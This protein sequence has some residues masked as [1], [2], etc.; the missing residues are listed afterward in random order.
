MKITLITSG[1]RGDVEPYV[2]LAEGLKDSGHMVTIA[3]E[4]RFESFVLGR[5]LKFFC[6]P[7]DTH[8]AINSPEGQAAL[9]KKDNTASFLNH[10]TN[11]SAA[12][13]TETIS[14]CLAAC[15]DA[16]H[17]ICT[18]FSLH[19]AY[20]LSQELNI[21]YSM[22]SVNPMVICQTDEFTNMMFPPAAEWL[23]P[24]MV[25]AYNSFSHKTVTDLW[26]R[27]YKKL[28]AAAVKKVLGVTLSSTDPFR[29]AKPPLTLF[30]YSPS[31]LPK[32]KNWDSH[33]HV[34]GYWF[35]KPDN[36]WKPSPGLEAF[37]EEGPK[38]I[39]IGFGSMNNSMLKKGEVEK[40]LTDTI[41][42]TKQRAVILKQG[43]NFDKSRLEESICA[44]EPVPFEYLFQKMNLLVHH[45]GA[46][47]TA[48]GLKAGVPAVLTPLIVDQR[49]WSWRV[50]KL[51]VSP[52]P[53]HWHSLT[54]DKLV[55]AINAWVDNKPAK[56]RAIELGKRIAA[57]NGVENA[58]RIFN[59]SI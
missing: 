29:T 59:N 51:N 18:Q 50:E 22:A 30:G 6:I 24:A 40:L 2:A 15:Q 37:I 36:S 21:P 23:P 10:L 52:A 53:I 25:R 41:R 31:V 56:D 17:I 4:A 27:S 54:K 8:A 48:L 5:G 12:F 1:S 34:C 33:Q 46:G 43:L 42:Q 45:G 55:T 35:L 49:F 16:D 28:Y 13:V 47:T 20:F 3:T 58:V 11:A 32:P 19:T 57:E 14:Q 44:T 9:N 38:P 7:G 26:W 39:Y